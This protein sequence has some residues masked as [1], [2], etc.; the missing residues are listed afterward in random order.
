MDEPSIESQNDSNTTKHIVQNFGEELTARVCVTLSMQ[1][2]LGNYENCHYSIR[3][4]QNCK[5]EDR[6][7]MTELLEREASAWIQKR[8]QK[9]DNYLR[10][11]NGQSENEGQSYQ[12]GS[13]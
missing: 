12:Q 7:S 9:V 4:E 5:P 3:Y 1:R 11:Q 8:T 10:K 13:R 2:N 6:G